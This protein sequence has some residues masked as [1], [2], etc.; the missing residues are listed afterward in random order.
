MLLCCRFKGEM[1]AEA[2]RGLTSE[3]CGAETASLLQRL[4]V[5]TAV[6]LLGRGR[7][8]CMFVTVSRIEIQASPGSPGWPVGHP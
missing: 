7:R 6:D 8:W 1:S 5:L 2:L 4:I 3:N